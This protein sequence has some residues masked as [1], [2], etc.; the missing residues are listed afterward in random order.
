MIEPLATLPIPIA[1]PP[2]DITVRLTSNASISTKAIKMEKGMVKE[3][4]SELLK[5]HM[6]K[7]ITKKPLRGRCTIMT[8]KVR[9]TKI[10]TSNRP[11]SDEVI[12]QVKKPP[13]PIQMSK[14]KKRNKRRKN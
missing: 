1:S 10:E 9:T 3:A 13:S 4:I 8:S 5:F 12:N 14:L 11:P 7:I 2:M 6:K